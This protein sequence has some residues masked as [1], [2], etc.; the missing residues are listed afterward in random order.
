MLNIQLIGTS[1]T[2]GLGKLARATSKIILSQDRCRGKL[3]KSRM[4][5]HGHYVEECMLAVRH[6]NLVGGAQGLQ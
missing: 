5:A 2:I 6:Q 1:S 4:L 3:A